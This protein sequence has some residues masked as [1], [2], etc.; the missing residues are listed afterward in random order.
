[1]ATDQLHSSGWGL[2]AFLH[3]TSTEFIGRRCVLFAA[4]Q[5]LIVTGSLNFL[6]FAGVQTNDIT[7]ASLL[8]PFKDYLESTIIWLILFNLNCSGFFH[9]W[10]GWQTF[11][12]KYDLLKLCQLKKVSKQCLNVLKQALFQVCELNKERLQF[13]DRQR[14]AG[15]LLLISHQ[16]LLGCCMWFQDIAHFLLCISKPLGPPTSDSLIHSRWAQWD[17]WFRVQRH[18]YTAVS[19]CLKQLA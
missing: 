6:P 9:A 8:L 18:M 5:L 4:L 11:T 7:M 15:Y 1:M 19:A 17:I 3:C 14:W 13:V 16:L 2:S 12:A 10:F